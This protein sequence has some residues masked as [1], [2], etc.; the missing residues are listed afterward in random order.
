MILPPFQKQGHGAQLLQTFYNTCDS[1]SE[2]KD[3]TGTF[4]L[5]KSMSSYKMAV[6]KFVSDLPLSTIFQLY[7]DGYLY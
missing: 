7:H 5:Y 2:V 4:I 3:I 1:R 6:I